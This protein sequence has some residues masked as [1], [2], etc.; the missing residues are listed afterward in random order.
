MKSMQKKT[1]KKQ[2]S[3]SPKIKTRINPRSP[4]TR[5]T[6]CLNAGAILSAIYEPIRPRSNTSSED[7]T[8]GTK[9]EQDDLR[10]A[11]GKQKGND[12][13]FNK[14]ITKKEIEAEIRTIDGE[15][16]VAITEKDTSSSKK[17]TK[18]SNSKEKAPCKK[19]KKKDEE[20]RD[21]TQQD[22][23]KEK[24]GRKR[25]Q[26]ENVVIDDGPT[27]KRMASLNAT[28]NYL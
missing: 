7:T 27:V 26:A 16:N 24:K 13:K 17:T 11:K 10:G 20:I 4:H 3:T 22:I 9:K 5:R 28:V 21:Q 18:K 14:K 25:K 6:A 2:I 19:Y 15:K 8:P 23:K 12:G 1:A